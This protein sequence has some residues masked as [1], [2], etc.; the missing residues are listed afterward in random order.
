MYI[1]NKTLGILLFI[2]AILVT[3]NWSIAL[4]PNE[5]LWIVVNV[6]FVA[7]PIFYLINCSCSSD[8]PSEKNVDPFFFSALILIAVGTIYQ[9]LS[10]N[11]GAVGDVLWS[12]LHGFSV[13]LY[14]FLAG[15]MLGSRK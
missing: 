9:L 15:K 11:F 12:Y 1:S 8:K 3:W 6:L 5:I 13:L 2:T 7:F 10:G 14:A 4:V